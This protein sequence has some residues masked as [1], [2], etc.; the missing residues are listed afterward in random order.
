MSITEVLLVVSTV[1]NVFS[2]II[3]FIM[4]LNILNMKM[5]VQ[6]I[7]TGLSTTL[8]KLFT[9]EHVLGKI[10]N[11]FSEFIRLT[12]SMVDHVNGTNDK[13]L[14]KT[15]DGRYTARTVDE[16]ID[17]IKKDGNSDEYFTDEELD[18]LKNMFNSDD[19]NDEED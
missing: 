13:V 18:K 11:G 14:Y 17:K 9:I 19:D 16:L 15:T 6:Q 1:I 8:A 12:E 7:H 2:I 3:I 5:Q 10:G 4:F